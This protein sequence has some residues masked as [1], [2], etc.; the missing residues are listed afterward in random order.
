MYK[1]FNSQHFLTYKLHENDEALVPKEF[2]FSSY[3]FYKTVVV[4][5]RL[6]HKHPYE[7]T[8]RFSKPFFIRIPLMK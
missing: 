7:S 4:V 2:D 8:A 1:V 6:R 5:V 3:T